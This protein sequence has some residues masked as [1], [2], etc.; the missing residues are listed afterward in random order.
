[1]NDGLAPLAENDLTRQVLVALRRQP[2]HRPAGRRGAQRGHGVLRGHHR[3]HPLA[4]AP[5]AAAP[6]RR[7]PR[8]AR[9]Q[10]RHVRHRARRE[11]ALDR[12]RQAGG[13]G[14]HRLQGARRRARLPVHRAV[15]DAWWRRPPPMPARQIANAHT[16]FN[17]GDQRAVPAVHAAGRPGRSTRWCPTTSAAENPYRTRY[18]DDRYLDQPSLAHRAGHARGAAH[19]RRRPGHAA[20]RDGGAPRPTTRSCSRTSSGATTSSTTSSA[21]SSSSWRGSGR[22]TMSPDLAQKEIA[23]ISFIGNLENIGDIIDKNLM[24]LG[25]QEALP[26]PPLLGGGRDRAHRVPRPRLE[27]PR[28]GHRGVRR[29]RPRASR[30]RCSTSGRDRPPA[31]ARAARVAPRPAARAGWPSRSRRRR[32]TSTC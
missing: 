29:Q 26:G 28:A 3:A 4:R 8:R 18:L 6:R 11:P 15:H 14:P 9:R 22:E 13:G 32:S 17:V 12:R 23:L 2:V 16:F 1:M 25:A 20:R 21:R 31:R 27:E 10:H 7:G 19:G 24:E 30:R 5:G